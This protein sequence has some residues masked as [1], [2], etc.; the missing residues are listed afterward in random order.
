MRYTKEEV[1]EIIRTNNFDCDG[2][3][4]FYHRACDDWLEIAT[5]LAQEMNKEITLALKEE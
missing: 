3:F 5:E 1:D 4:C 2:S